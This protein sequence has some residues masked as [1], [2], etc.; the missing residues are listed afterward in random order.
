MNGAMLYEQLS[1][2]LYVEGYALDEFA[3]NRLGLI[4][5]TKKSQKIGLLLDKSI[6]EDIRIRHIQVAEAFR[7]TLGIDVCSCVVTNAPIGVSLATSSSGASW[8]CIQNIDT[9]I[10]GAN[11]LIQDGCTAIAVVARFPEDESDEEKAAF[12]AYRKQGGVDGIAGTVILL[13]FV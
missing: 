13:D 4:Q 6:E 9:L 12:D 7:A 3:S 1:N 11:E 10:H 2:V 5:C 8:G